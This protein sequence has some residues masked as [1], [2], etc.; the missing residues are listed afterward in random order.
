MADFK[1]GFE[2]HGIKTAFAI[3]PEEEY[4]KVT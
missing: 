4:E 1:T 3:G 2:I